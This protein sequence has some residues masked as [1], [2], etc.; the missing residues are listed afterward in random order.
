MR[1]QPWRTSLGQKTTAAEFATDPSLSR[2]SST[3]ACQHRDV[4]ATPIPTGSLALDFDSFLVDLDGVVYVGPSAIPGAADTLNTLTEAGHRVCFVTNNASRPPQAVA[5]H[6]TEL[7][8]AASSDDVLTSAQAGAALIKRQVAAGSAVLA[9]GGPGVA[10]AL[11]A[12]G[13]VVVDAMTDP[14]ASTGDDV[15][16]VLQGFGPDVG[17]RALARAAFVV[18]RGL[19]WVATNTDLTIPVAQ[20]IAPGN[21]TLVA[22]VAQATGRSPEVAGK[23]FPPLLM[24]AAQ[25]SSGLSP[26]V[27]G[28]RLDTDIQGAGNAKMSSL[29]VMTGVTGALDLWRAPS[30]QRPDYIALD[31]AGLLDVPRRV[32]TTD[33]VTRCGQASAQLQRTRLSI[34]INEDPLGAVWAAAHAIW[35]APGEPDNAIEWSARLDGQIRDLLAPDTDT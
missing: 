15:A 2:A 27:V 21:G 30:Y 8:V 25:H 5:A 33:G 13:F 22:A 32:T 31:V 7:G 1:R 14:L 20:G 19:P 11:A 26:L 17:W 35:A 16:A 28:D 3:H 9:V 29:L 34:E 18:A 24:A 4:S 23:P 10:A 12:E 6:L